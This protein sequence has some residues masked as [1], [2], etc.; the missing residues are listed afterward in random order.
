MAQAMV[1]ARP[2]S[3]PLLP[4]PSRDEAAVGSLP[5]IRSPAAPEGSPGRAPPGAESAAPRPSPAEPAPGAEGG[6]AAP[7][8]RGA[9]CENPLLRREATPARQIRLATPGD[10]SENPLLPLELIFDSDDEVSS[11]AA[12]VTA[13]AMPPSLPPLPPCSH[14][15]APPSRGLPA[16][17]TA[18]GSSPR[19][20]APK[21]RPSSFRRAREAGG[22]AA[23]PPQGS[24]PDAKPRAS[25]SSRPTTAGEETASGT[26]RTSLSMSSATYTADDFSDFAKAFAS[27][28]DIT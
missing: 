7:K 17:G 3:P 21:L 26:S 5:G 6:E 10:N 8:S 25:L 22:A 15:Q 19:P 12:D 13:G 2:P 20:L 4:P 28:G 1:D 11:A 18:P 16:Q 27:V 24:S 9:S 23:Q 14:G